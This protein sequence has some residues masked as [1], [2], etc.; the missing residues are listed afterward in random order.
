MM[1]DRPPICP[2][3]DEVLSKRAARCFHCETKLEAWWPLE[4]SL[5]EV[6]SP[7]K[8]SASSVGRWIWSLAAVLVGVGLGF[9]W[10]ELGPDETSVVA[11]PPA[12][13]VT[14]VVEQ[15]AAVEE[16]API[17]IHYQVQRGDSLWRVASALTGQGSDWSS[18]W[19]D[20]AGRERELEVGAVLQVRAGELVVRQ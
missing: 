5:L 15:L 12:P 1:E 3:C 11:S 14:Q 7:E 10:R 13:V 4:E 18:L 2:V 6:D 17:I 19:P 16:S 9:G 20:Y 8:R